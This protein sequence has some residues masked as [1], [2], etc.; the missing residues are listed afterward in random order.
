MARR[1]LCTQPAIAWAALLIGA[2][3]VYAADAQQFPAPGPSALRDLTTDRPDTTESPFTI[4]AGHLQI[5]T[6]LF[7]YSRTPRDPGGDSAETF[8]FATTNLRIG[9]THSLELDLV[10]H[11]YGIAASGGGAR[12]DGIGSLDVRAKLN[13]WGNDG[14]TTAFALLPYVSIPIDRDNGVSPPD[15]EYGMLIPLSVD[16]GGRLGLGLNAGVNARRDDRTTPY[17][18]CGIATAS[19][20]VSWTNR[21]GSYYEIAVEAGGDRPAATSLNTGVTWRAR[22]TLQLDAG[23]QFGVGG[24]AAIFGPFIGFSLRL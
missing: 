21:L 14:G 5:E 11:P 16:L 2:A 20:A 3:P 15:I 9:L 23:T 8:E 12:R 22:D 6:T 17:R 1:Y 4:D 7:G 10:A 24:D 13:L 19:L 18:V